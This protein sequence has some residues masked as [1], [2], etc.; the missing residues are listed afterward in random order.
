MIH[1]SYPPVYKQQI[2][3][4]TWIVAVSSSNNQSDCLFCVTAYPTLDEYIQVV[5]FDLFQ[6]GRHSVPTGF[7]CST[8]EY[9]SAKIW[10]WDDAAL[11]KSVVDTFVSC[12]NLMIPLELFYEFGGTVNGCR[13]LFVISKEHL[14]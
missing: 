10:A 1:P 6:V 14:H 5:I 12:S 8:T 11:V 4:A 2:D 9:F 3:E 13:P 7:F